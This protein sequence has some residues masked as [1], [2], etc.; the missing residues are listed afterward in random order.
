[1]RMRLVCPGMRHPLALAGAYGLS[2][3][4]SFFSSVQSAEYTDFAPATA[5]ATADS[6]S[7]VRVSVAESDLVQPAGCE[8]ISGCGESCAAAAD[9]CQAGCQ[10]RRIGSYG[11]GGTAGGGAAAGGTGDAMLAASGGVAAAGA[12]ALPLV[13]G[14]TSVGTCAQMT[15]GL[16]DVNLGHP[17][18]QCSRL[19]LAEYNSPMPTD[20]IFFAYRH[21]SK[22]TEVR[23]FWRRSWRQPGRHQIELRAGRR[24][25]HL[26]PRANLLQRPHVV[27][28]PATL[29]LATLLGY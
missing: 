28:S 16:V 9:C 24:S 23:A 14:D 27:G 13:I 4:L 26:R 15:L 3:L 19:N 22:A 6:P 17:N 8:A 7:D 10:G 20:R 5:A 29:V 12:A 1:M 21:F 18:L 2:L 11:R 25:L